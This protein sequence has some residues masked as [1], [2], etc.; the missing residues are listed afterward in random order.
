MA[1]F[2]EFLS[3]NDILTIFNPLTGACDK[4]P[5][6]A[7]KTKVSQATVITLKMQSLSTDMGR[8]TDTGLMLLMGAATSA[9]A[10]QRLAHAALKEL[11]RRY[12]GYLLTVVEGFSEN[13]GTVEIDPEEFANAAFKKAFLCAASFQDEC[14]GDAELSTRKLKA[15]LGIVAKNLARDALDK[16]KRQHEHL[17]TVPI[18]EAVEPPGAEPEPEL[19]TTPTATPVLE[20]LREALDALKPE[21]RD[22]L[23]TYA[24][25]GFNT[26]NGRE[27]PKDVREALEDRTGYERGNIRQKWLRLTRK[28]KAE[29]Q[30]LMTTHRTLNP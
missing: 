26:K 2:S 5:L 18:D 9:P 7:K 11:H 6:S 3:V 16:I 14:N 30:P 4:A 12:Y 29:L 28:L 22:I 13:F 24:S 17:Q 20:A 25:F 8:E 21:E 15:W 23:I 10:E 27:L 1:A 19:D